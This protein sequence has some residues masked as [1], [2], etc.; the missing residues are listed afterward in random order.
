M[1]HGRASLRRASVPCGNIVGISA[2]TLLECC[3]HCEK[4]K[5]SLN[6]MLRCQCAEGHG[7]RVWPLR[8]NISS[9]Y[10]GGS[11]HRGGGWNRAKARWAA[12]V[13]IAGEGPCTH[14]H[15]PSLSRS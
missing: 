4:P 2:G 6:T 10:M 5:G 14:A 11:H 13:G 15:N 9:M 1:R 12:P 7:P 3:A 8:A